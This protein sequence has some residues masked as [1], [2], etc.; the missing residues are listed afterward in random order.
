YRHVFSPELAR[1]MVDQDQYAGLTMSG[2]SRRAF[3]PEARMHPSPAR[4][5]LDVRFACERQMIEFGV[6]YTL[7]T[8]AGVMLTPIHQFALGMRAAALELRLTPAEVLTAITRTAAEALS[9]ADRGTVV[10]GKRAD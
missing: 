9:L 2:L 7:H 3:V 10:A 1:R 8:D 4:Q 5:R 6:Q